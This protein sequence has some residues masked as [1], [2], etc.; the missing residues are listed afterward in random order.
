MKF[1]RFAVA[2]MLAVFLSAGSAGA[3]EHKH[4]D[5]AQMP[6][7]RVAAV[8]KEKPSCCGKEKCPM[9]K[10]G[11][12]CEDMPCCKSGKCPMMQGHAAHDM[13]MPEA[14]SASE[15]EL[16]VAMSDMHSAMAKPYT[17]DADADFI[18]GMIPHHAGAVE[19]ARIELQYGD[20]EQAR[21]LARRII[22]AQK[23]EIAWMQKWLRQRQIP[24]SGEFK[25]NR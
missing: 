15:K 13:S 21:D 5:M 12:K 17:G 10:E 7:V 8:E 16:A 6:A 20:D 1:Y 18:R 9:M 19:M 11:M 14:S 22:V 25:F 3:Q 23:G 24:E 4:H 2:L